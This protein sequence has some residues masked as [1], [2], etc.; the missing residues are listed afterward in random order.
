MNDKL[1]PKNI[2]LSSIII[3]AL[4]SAVIFGILYTVDRS[5]MNDNEPVLFS[6]WGSKYAPVLTAE[7]AFCGTVLEESSQYM[8][9]EPSIDT[10]DAF[11]DETVKT[12]K[13]EYPAEHSDYLYGVG[14]KV[15]VYFDGEYTVSDSGACTIRTD[16]IS[17]EG[18]RDFEIN[19]VP[20][21]KKEKRKIVIKS[22]Q[23]SLSD[24]DFSLYYYGIENAVLSVQGSAIPLEKALAEGKITLAGIIARC[25]RDVSNGVI[26]K[27]SYNDGG[28]QLYKYP[29]FTIIKYHTSDGNRD[30]YIGSSDMDI[31][32]LSE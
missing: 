8:L 6:T 3:L 29:D 18:F 25:N 31:D 22:G 23:S 16:D 9:V 12:V 30:V 10:K 20:S 15:V 32:I 7:K 1:S 28:S 19:I 5:R 11:P 2:L 26:D 21:N 17:T 24:T 13:I 27:I 4:F 14:R